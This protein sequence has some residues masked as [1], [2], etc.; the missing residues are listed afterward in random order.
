[1]TDSLIYL[2][3]PQVAIDPSV[4]VPD[5]GLSDA[6]RARAEALAGAAALAGVT[7]IVASGEKKA[8]ETAE[9][10]AAPLGLTVDI[11]V[12]THENDRSA[13]GFLPPPEFEAAA[14]A[15]FA[16]PAESFRGWEKAIEAQARIVGE[17]RGV[18]GERFDVAP[19]HGDV[20][21]VGHGGVGTL[22]YCYFAH[23]TISREHD[24][25]PTGGGCFW[26]MPLDSL[27]PERGWRP[28]EEMLEPAGR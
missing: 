18:I 26:R 25:P 28:M 23:L 27:K 3:H 13:T 5:W 21:M 16:R 7:R 4:P 17:T 10:L 1:M 2:S 11:R 19:H 20:L 9:I 14:D 12:R 15:F 24:Q 8:I 6:G 22:L